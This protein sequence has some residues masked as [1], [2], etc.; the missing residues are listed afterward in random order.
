MAVSKAKNLVV[1][2]PK[3]LS[4]Y[5]FTDVNPVGLSHQSQYTFKVGALVIPPFENF[6]DLTEY[7][8]YFQQQFVDTTTRGNP[9]FV[10]INMDSATGLYSGKSTMK[11]KEIGVDTIL[12]SA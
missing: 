8:N 2:D 9:S 12:A 7:I 5:N 11:N 6:R 4:H 1:R 10:T 3:F